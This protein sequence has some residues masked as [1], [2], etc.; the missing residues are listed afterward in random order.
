[1]Y[2]TVTTW[3]NTVKDAIAKGMTL[4]EA[5][6]KVTMAKQFPNLPRDERTAGIIQMNVTRLYEV[7]KK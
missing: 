3:I 2:D 7:L 6:S 1:M 4:K 5:Q